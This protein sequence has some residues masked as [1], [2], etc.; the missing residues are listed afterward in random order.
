M[1]NN[2]RQS[3][4]EVCDRDSADT[5]GPE[6]TQRHDP[7]Q[8]AFKWLSSKNDT[9]VFAG[10]ALLKSV[11]D[12]HTKTV[13]DTAWITQC[14]HAIPPSFL[15]R[16]LAAKNSVSLLDKHCMQEAQ[17]KFELGV[18]VLHAFFSFMSRSN[19]NFMLPIGMSS[20]DQQRW[21]SRT[22]NLTFGLEKR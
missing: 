8:Q 15:D 22:E 14:W 1:T 5:G 4:E 3:S 7:L 19:T 12:N 6:S 13:E 10:L 18:G 21:K 2:H 20:K 16:L 9:Q 11:I 17:A